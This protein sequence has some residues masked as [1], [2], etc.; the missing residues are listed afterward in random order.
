MNSVSL[1]DS[2]DPLVLSCSYFN[3]GSHL[4]VNCQSN[5][6]LQTVSYLLNSGAVVNGK[7]E[8]IFPNYVLIPN[9][10]KELN[11]LSPFL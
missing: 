3:N 11:C 2:P 4:I 10:S 7:K 5:N 9:S 1:I 8:I 6:Q